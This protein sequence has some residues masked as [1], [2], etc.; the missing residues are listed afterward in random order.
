[1]SAEVVPAGETGPGLS[2]AQASETA[3]VSPEVYHWKTVTNRLGL[4]LFLLSDSF[5]FAGLF[6]ARFYLYGAAT[7]PDVNQYVG[8][9]V[10]IMLLASSFFANR[11]ETLMRAGDVKGYLRN[12]LITIVLG[13]LFLIGVVGIEWQ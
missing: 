10:T 12:T 1:M 13:V 6:I 5:V 9:V 7:R 4:W 11:G 2:P 3:A 8:V